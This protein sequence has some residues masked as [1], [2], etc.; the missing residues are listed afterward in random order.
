MARRTSIDAATASGIHDTNRVNVAFDLFRKQVSTVM[1]DATTRSRIARETA[2]RQSVSVA[3]AGDFPVV[4]REEILPHVK[5]VRDFAPVDYLDLIGR[6]FSNL[7]IVDTIRRVAFDGSSRHTG[8]VLP[9]LRDGLASGAPVEGLALVE[10]VRARMCEGTREDGTVIEPNDPLWDTLVS[11]AKAAR[12][13]PCAWLEQRRFYGD[14]VEAPRFA[15]AFERRL[16]RIWSDGC[17]ASMQ[18]YAAPLDHAATP[19]VE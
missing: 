7:A 18:A 17:Q 3:A 13:R 10:A 4:Q 12:E 15:D 19:E 9:I 8:F 14:L 1:I 16:E 6:R 11:A 2:S 5:P